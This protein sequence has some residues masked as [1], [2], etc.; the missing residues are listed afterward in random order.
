MNCL[1]D[2]RGDFTGVLFSAIVQSKMVREVTET[3][4]NVFICSEC[5]HRSKRSGDLSKHI[6]AKH[7]ENGGYNCQYCNKYCPSLNA[8]RSHVS[9]SHK[10]NL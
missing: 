2:E 3:G 7:I 8:M 1:K 4:E 5:G 10:K 9:R 6:E